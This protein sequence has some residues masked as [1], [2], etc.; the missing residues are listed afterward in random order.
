MPRHGLLQQLFWTHWSQEQAKR[1]LQ[2]LSS[3][4]RTM[5]SSSNQ[6]LQCM[7]RKQLLQAWCKARLPP[8]LPTSFRMLFCA[9]FFA[10]PKLSHLGISLTLN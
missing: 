7:R 4:G 6:S 3:K 10:V 1:P 5:R 2:R 8:Q 9:E